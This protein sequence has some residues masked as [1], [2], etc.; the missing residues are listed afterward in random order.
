MTPTNEDW[1]NPN[2]PERWLG[3]QPDEDMAA[4]DF[5]LSWGVPAPQPLPPCR[6]DPD[7]RCPGV[8]Q[9]LPAERCIH[10]AADT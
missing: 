1:F 9:I 4:I 6:K 8:C 10:D 3:Y 5:I 2:D 7:K